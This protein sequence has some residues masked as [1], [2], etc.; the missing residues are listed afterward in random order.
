MVP[1]TD[2]SVRF[3]IYLRRVNQKTKAVRY[4]MPHVQLDDDGRE[5]AVSFASKKLNDTQRNWSSTDG[6]AFAAVWA[7]KNYHAYL[8]GNPFTLVTD[9]SALTFIMKAKDL[10]GKL[11]RYT[12]RLQGYTRLP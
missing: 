2:G 11:A 4:P 6:E 5:Y 10:T 9:N 12:M 7:I 3:C 1:K 8:Y